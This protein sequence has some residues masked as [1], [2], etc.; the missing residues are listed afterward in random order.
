MTKKEDRYP[1][2]LSRNCREARRSLS[3]SLSRARALSPT[4][5]RF[6]S[7]ARNLSLSLAIARARALSLS[8]TLS[9]AR[10]LSL[11]LSLSLSH[12]HSL[13]L[14]LSTPDLQRGAQVSLVHGIGDAER[15]QNL[16]PAVNMAHVR[17][18]R[19]DSGIGFQVK[20]LKTFQVV[21][22]RPYPGPAARIGGGAGAWDFIRTS[23]HDEYD[24]MLFWHV[25]LSILRVYI[26][27][28]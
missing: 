15:L 10:D 16:R 8:R 24:L 5:S 23:I 22:K 3:L 9:R 27:S 19:P 4:P 1:S 11:S 26:N 18:S 20:L 25:F 28:K 12:T 14:S 7:P 6:L 2:T 17:Q 13:S 21:R